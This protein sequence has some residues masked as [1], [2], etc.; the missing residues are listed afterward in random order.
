VPDYLIKGGNTY[1]II[2]DH[3]GSPRLIINTQDGTIAQRLDYDEYGNVLTDTNPGFQPFGFAGGLYDSDT[4]LVQFGARDYDPK[5]G[6]WT[7]KDPIDFDGGD[8]NLYSYVLNDPINFV[9]P[10]GLISFKDIRDISRGVL[11][12]CPQAFSCCDFACFFKNPLSVD[13][14]DLNFLSGTS[15]FVVF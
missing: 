10:F 7:S 9:D 15:P 8:T 6:R 3:L 4:G 12:V 1:R 5:I 13:R 11:S 14:F 2:S